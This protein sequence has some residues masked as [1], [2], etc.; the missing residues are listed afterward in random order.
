M[1][2]KTNTAR[3]NRVLENDPFFGWIKKR[4]RKLASLKK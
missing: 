2:Y 1:E 4:D 3:F